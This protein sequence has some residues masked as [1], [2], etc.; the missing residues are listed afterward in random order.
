MF[1]NLYLN[2]L[3]LIYC[4]YFIYLFFY[5]LF[6]FL[7]TVVIFLLFVANLY[8]LTY[9]WRGE[10]DFLLWEISALFSFSPSSSAETVEAACRLQPAKRVNFFYS[11]ARYLIKVFDLFE[12][13]NCLFKIHAKVACLLNWTSGQL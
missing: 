1:F 2:L 4:K 13:V 8:L 10:G 7:L 3:K 6:P 9:L 11:L 5:F 12:D